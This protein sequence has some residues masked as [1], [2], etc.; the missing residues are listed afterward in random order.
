MEPE[1]TPPLPSGG[2]VLRPF[3]HT[4]AV[5]PAPE[6][7]RHVYVTLAALLFPLSPSVPYL[8][9]LSAVLLAAW[10][11]SLPGVGC[12]RILAVPLCRALPRIDWVD[13]LQH[14]FHCSPT[15]LIRHLN[16]RTGL[17]G[18]RGCQKRR[19]NC[20]TCLYPWRSFLATSR[21]AARPRLF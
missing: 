14:N 13:I 2:I 12:L 8:P 3:A 1:L 15:V 19:W 6:P 4:A 21:P 9:L 11:L 16:I 17:T 7:I 10:W 20:E 5:Q 18:I